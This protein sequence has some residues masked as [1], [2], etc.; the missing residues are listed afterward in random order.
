MALEDVLLT[1][2][3]FLPTRDLLGNCA[4]VNRAFFKA[5]LVEELWLKRYRLVVGKG[6]CLEPDPSWS[7]T[8]SGSLDICRAAIVARQGL[9]AYD[10]REFS[11]AKELFEWSVMLT[12]HKEPISLALLG[13]VCYA[14]GER[15]ESREL[16]ES[17]LK[18]NPANSYAVN[19]LALFEAS[20]A[21]QEQ[22]LRR[23]I[24]LDSGNSYALANLGCLLSARES[25]E[26]FGLLAHALDINKELFYARTALAGLHLA[27]DNLAEALKYAAEQLQ[28]IPN[29]EVALTIV[30]RVV[31]TRR[32]DPETL[33]HLI[34]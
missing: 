21:A 10:K 5:T 27:K 4:V 8:P 18:L 11:L 19:G 17:A 6:I 28:I 15:L 34:S 16:Y 14:E 20:P 2:F 22:M 30:F 9:E 1:V 3:H 33:S 31:G 32:V 25:E 23:A 24:E 13:N 12:R 7:P 29:D 26:A